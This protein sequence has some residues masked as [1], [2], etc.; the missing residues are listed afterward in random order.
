LATGAPGD[1]ERPYRE[2]KKQTDNCTSFQSRNKIFQNEQRCIAS[3]EENYLRNLVFN[4]IKSGCI[5]AQ[6]FRAN[7][8][9]LGID[10]V[11]DQ[12]RPHV[13]IVI[14]AAGRVPGRGVGA[15]PA[16]EAR[17]AS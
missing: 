6:Y 15:G 11:H 2:G 12:S 7:E 14:T 9:T 5:Q 13:L 1:F 8:V 16:D 10:A 17:G 3:Y 4:P